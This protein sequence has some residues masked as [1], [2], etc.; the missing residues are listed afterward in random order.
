MNK[1]FRMLLPKCFKVNN[2]S[3]DQKEFKRELNK[4]ITEEG[5]IN[6]S[7]CDINSFITNLEDKGLF[8]K[9][10]ILIHLPTLS[11]FDRNV[12]LAL[13]RLKMTGEAYFVYKIKDYINKDSNYIEFNITF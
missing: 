6:V 7:N 9:E 3:N 1:F 8:K 10:V 2:T 11:K 5:F 13:V 12:N 4:I